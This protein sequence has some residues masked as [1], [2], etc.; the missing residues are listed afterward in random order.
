MRRDIYIYIHKHHMCEIYIYTNILYY[1][2]LFCI[3]LYY[4]ILYHI[5]LYCIILYH[6]YII[7]QYVMLYYIT[8]YHILNCI[9]LIQQT[10]DT[11]AVRVVIRLTNII[12]T[13]N[14]PKTSKDFV[15]VLSTKLDNCCA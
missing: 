7:I 8:L 9:I 6:I 10:P 1:I 4:T 12:Q 3:I 13:S 5:V 2:T 15:G 14:D 11:K